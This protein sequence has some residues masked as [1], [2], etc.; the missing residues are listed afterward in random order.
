M[1]SS[2]A[3]SSGPS[4]SRTVRTV[5]WSQPAPA[6]TTSAPGT[7]PRARHAPSPARRR[8]HRARRRRTRD[9]AGGVLPE[10]PTAKWTCHGCPSTS[11]EACA[12]AVTLF[13]PPRTE[14]SWSKLDFVVE[15]DQDAGREA[16]AGLLKRLVG[17]RTTPAPAP[18]PTEAL[19][20]TTDWLTDVWD[21]AAIKR[22]P[23]ESLP[24]AL[25]DAGAREFLASLG[26]PCVTGFLELDTTGLAS[27]GLQPVA[28]VAEPVDDPAE[29][30]TTYFSLG[31]WQGSRLLLN[32]RDGRVLLDGS[33]GIDD[34]LAGS[35]LSRFVAMARLYYWWFASDWSIEDTESDVRHWL[36]LIDHQ[37]Y[38][39]QGWQR[40]FEDYNFG[41]RV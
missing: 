27:A 41:D 9:P 17:T 10:P 28:D 8:R 21:A 25:S 2:A 12:R 32:G 34:T 23:Q 37:A 29:A 33:S 15:L 22:F 30:H 18:L 35:S 36:N 6:A 5:T 39:T 31:W 4:G 16:P 13:W 19:A 20:P 3:R 38:A 24:S 14:C 1:P 11:A 40:V 7:W 26:F